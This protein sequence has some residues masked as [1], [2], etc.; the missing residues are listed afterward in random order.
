M[1]KTLIYMLLCALSFGA[2]NCDSHF[3][4]LNTDPSRVKADAF[5]PQY[6]LTTAQLRYSGSADF[7]Y[8]TWRAQLIY[9][10]T[11]VQHFATTIG[12]WAGDKYAQ[13]D[14]YLSAYWERSYDEQVKNVVDLVEL[15]REKP[16]LANLHNVG[17]IMKVLIFHRIT[18]LYGDIPYFEAGQGFYKQ[19]FTPKYDKQEDIYADMLKELSE[20]TAAL[21]AETDASFSGDLMY[22]GDLSKWKKFGN[23]LMLRLGMRLTKVNEAQAKEWAEKAVQG[24]VM[25]SI[26]DNAKILHDAAGGRPTVNRISQVLATSNPENQGYV[27]W[28]KTFVDYLKNTNDPRLPVIAQTRNEA[29]IFGLPNGYELDIT[30]E[31]DISKAPNYDAA[32]SQYSYA[33]P[34]SFLID[35]GAPTFFLTYGEVELLLAEAAQRGFSTGG[36]AESHY[37]AGVTAS[38]KTISQYPGSTAI[39]DVAI[40]NY[41]TANPFDQANALEVINSQYWVTTI[42]NDYEA[43]SNWR[44]SGYPVLTPVDHRAGVTGGVIPRRFPY[45]A[46]EAAA[47]AAN[48]DEAV[49]RLNGGNTLISRV[50]WDKQ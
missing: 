23:S 44:R 24:G 16:E 32:L 40:A 48:L 14:A 29:G 20:A 36:T 7:S 17:R 9:T 34:A 50:W 10:S 42:M 45:P 2:T 35:L 4:E 37:I 15:T 12:Y 5:N 8:E 18:D 3:E 22:G 26:D 49:S 39:D 6:L 21:P 25:A 33:G 30:Q 46:A 31:T 28:S 38:M 13:N 43:Y 11:M 47:N 41:L 27:R 1:K 19:I